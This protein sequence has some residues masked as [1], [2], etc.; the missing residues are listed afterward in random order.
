MKNLLLTLR[1]R[2]FAAAVLL[3]LGLAAPAAVR[4]Q[5]VWSG[6]DDRGPFWSYGEEVDGNGNVTHV[7]NW[8]GG[9][10]PAAGANVSL[11]APGNTLCDVT[12]TLNSLTI[13]PS[14]ALSFYRNNSLTVANTN[15]AA[16]GAMTGDG[17]YT[18]TGTLLK[19][20]GTGTYAFTGGLTVNS[21]PGTTIAVDA[22]LLQ[23]PGG[24]GVFDTMTFDPAA[25]TLI[26]L[27]SQNADGGS[28]DNVFQGTLTNGTGTGTVQ[29]SQGTIAGGS[30]PATLDFTGEV[31]QWTGGLIGTYQGGAIFTNT[32]VVNLSGDDTKATYAKFT[33]AGLFTQ[34]GAGTFNVGDYNSGGSFTNAAG[35]IYDLQSDANI[36]QSSYLFNNAGIFK[37]SGGTGTSTLTVSFQNQGGT[38]EADS[39]TLQLPVDNNGGTDTGGTFNA[40]AGALLDLGGNAHLTGT[41]TG[42]GAG[43]VR[44]SAGTLYPDKPAATTFNFPGSLFQWTGGTI[45]SYQGGEV[46]TNAGTIN[47]NGTGT[48]ETDAVFTNQGLITQGGTTVFNVGDYNSGGSFTNAAGATYDLQSDANIG[49]GDY[50]FNNAGLFKKSGGTGISTFTSAFS[51]LGGTV[52]VDSGTLQLP[53]NTGGNS[54]ST[55][56]AFNVAAGALLDLGGGGHFTGT[57]TG[58]GAGTV[59]FSAG[60]FYTDNVTGA[61]LNFPGGMFQWTGGVFG[62]GQSGHIVVNDGT[63]NLSGDGDKATYANIT[64]N[65]AMIQAGAGNLDLGQG[66]SGGSLTN[67]AGATYDLQSDA[68]MTNNDRFTN[69]GMFQ[70]SA[71]T[72][73]STIDE[74]FTNTGTTAVLSGT[75]A[76]VDNVDA[77]TNGS[78]LATGTWNI[79][80]GASI[81]FKNYGNLTVNQANVTLN[82]PNAAFPPINALTDNQGSLSL[83]ALRQFTTAG[84][85]SNEGTIVLDAG[86]TLHVA[87]S[88][89]GDGSTPAASST[90]Q[91]GGNGVHTQAA[92]V[93]TLSFVV[94]GT[95]SQGLLSP[96]LMQVGTRAKMGGLIEIAL[97]KLAA[98]PSVTDGVVLVS[99]PS[100]TG[101]F[102]NAPDGTRLNTTDGRGSYVV[103]YGATAIGLSRF[104]APGQTETTPV[105]TV[106]VLGDGDAV[107]G[108]ENGK[109]AIRR[110]GD[111]TGALTVRYK[112]TG[113]VVAG[114]DYKPL[115]GVAVIP[116]GA[117]QVKIKLKPINDTIHEG[118][119]TAKIKLKPATDGSYALGSAIAAKVHLIDND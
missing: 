42:S 17:V 69:A 3:L 26:D 60:S 90:H 48:V 7:G 4:A 118:T 108:G 110:A 68:G 72:G 80:D 63:I 41:Y 70:K 62:G 100:I 53:T 111:I 43:T 25:G 99:A 97:S 94:G 8:S 22:G 44:L 28:F 54:T 45:G 15:F 102:A 18:N 75:L 5:S 65:G 23:L 67:A 24:G 29:L 10:P 40:A 61:T 76:F 21:T 74:E 56:G 117:T 93:P 39:G 55:G 14:G 107:E 77:V 66:N 47:I 20:A 79:S 37:K 27:V 71:G 91:T 104:L 85:L 34:S 115:P 46:F 95:A 114:V 36:G 112:V 89:T 38:V 2:P 52:E 86:S 119:R 50:T 57:Y 88:Y 33:N 84:D 31:F 32:G 6:A 49:Q 1:S 116:A 98:T 101:S 81:T 12:I 109:V 82:G 87:G 58:S 16:D 64:N 19:S 78:T 92:A 59:R 103:N 30:A 96:G 106:A 35:A 83:L 13:Q 73:T 11:G 113:G 9:L 51:L 105:V